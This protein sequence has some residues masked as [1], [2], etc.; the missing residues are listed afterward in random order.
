MR[1]LNEVGY[2]GP[3]RATAFLQAV[4]QA[5]AMWFISDLS[6]SLTYSLRPLGADTVTCKLES[7]RGIR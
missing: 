4:E 1:N 7:L 6:P 3:Q 2:P 5:A